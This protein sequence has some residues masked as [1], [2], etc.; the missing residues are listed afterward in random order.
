MAAL[1]R[2]PKRQPMRKLFAFL[3]NRVICGMLLMM[4]LL[5][6]WVFAIRPAV[7]SQPLVEEEA[8]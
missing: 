5:A 2:A 1:R 8:R 3:T 4:L 7:F 6:A